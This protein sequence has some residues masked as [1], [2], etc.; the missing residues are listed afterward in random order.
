MRI[1]LLSQPQSGTEFIKVYRS[2]VS[3]NTPTTI[4]G[5]VIH[6]DIVHKAS[7]VT[8]KK[9]K[10]NQKS[11]SPTKHVTFLRNEFHNFYVRKTFD[12]RKKKFN[13][14]YSRISVTSSES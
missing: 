6:V 10:K 7:H 8:R 5:I 1:N 13:A 11:H 9:Q 4:L 12:E 3:F 2:L 14:F